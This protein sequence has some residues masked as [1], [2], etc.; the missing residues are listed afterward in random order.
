MVIIIIITLTIS[1]HYPSRFPCYRTAY[2]Y[3]RGEFWHEERTLQQAVVEAYA[4][5]RTILR[6]SPSLT[7][8]NKK[9]VVRVMFC[10]FHTGSHWQ[11]CQW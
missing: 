1:Y 4:K 7:S 2:I 8:L 11:E 3:I 5:V 9:F 6:H 10:F